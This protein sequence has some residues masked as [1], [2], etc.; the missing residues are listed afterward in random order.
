MGCGCKQQPAPRPSLYVEHVQVDKPSF[1]KEDL[2]RCY[3][4]FT[5]REKKETE[6]QFVVNFHNHH[7]PEQFSIG[8]QVDG[9]DW[10]R[11]RKRIDHLNGQYNTYL[12]SL[13]KTK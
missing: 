10:M 8:I 12:N 1:S 5:S 7:F 6:K 3:D 9:E 11:L 4:F 2:N 13:N